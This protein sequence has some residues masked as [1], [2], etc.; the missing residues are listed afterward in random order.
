MQ[1]GI[2]LASVLS[3]M[4]ANGNASRVQ[5]SY[6]VLIQAGHQG[7]PA[8][9]QSDGGPEADWLCHNTGS[10]VPPGEK[11]WT[12]IV[13]DKT[14]R[15]LEAAGIRVLRLPGYVSGIY[16]VKAAV[17]IHF[18]G[19]VKPCSS[20]ASVGYPP[21]NIKDA[22]IADKWK[23]LYGKYWPYKIMRDNFTQNERRYYAYDNVVASDGKFLIES[24]EMS[25]PKQ[26]AWLRKHLT[27]EAAL[28]AHFLSND[29]RQGFIPVPAI[30]NDR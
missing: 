28:L 2:V 10:P 13:A 21:K 24:G 6:D 16:H 18:D 1:V 5:G 29:I 7:R 15:I 3:L 14:A 8:D 4:A 11:V 27:W 20:G 17:Y 12:Q 22:A 25:C 19:A 30:A 23:A 9:C 26:Y